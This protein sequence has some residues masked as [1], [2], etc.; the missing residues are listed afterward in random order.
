MYIYVYACVYI[1]KM[2]FLYLSL[3]L[4]MNLLITAHLSIFSLYLPFSVPRLIYSQL[5]D[6]SISVSCSLSSNLKLKVS[7]TKFQ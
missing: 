5:N 6:S 1:K 3:S 4:C 2:I 7:F